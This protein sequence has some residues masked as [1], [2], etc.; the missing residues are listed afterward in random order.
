MGRCKNILQ[1]QK[2][3]ADA[4][5]YCRSN[6]VDLAIIK[7]SDDWYWMIAEPEDIGVPFA[8]S[9]ENWIL[10]APVLIK[11]QVT[12]PEAQ[13]Y[14]R[15]NHLDLYTLQDSSDEVKLYNELAK[16]NEIRPV[17]VGLYNDLDSWYF[18][19]NRLP[20]KNISLRNFASGHPSVE[21]SNAACGAIE[22][23]GLWLALPCHYTGP[24]LC[25][26]ASNSPEHRFVGYINPGLSWHDAQTFCRTHHTD[27]AS[28]TTED[29]INLVKQLL[30]SIFCYGAWFGLTRDTWKWS[31][32]AEASYLPWATGQPDNFYTCE[33]CVGA[34]S[35]LL[36]DEAC[37]NL[38]YFACSD[39]LHRKQFV[40]LQVQTD[41]SVLDPAVQSAVLDLIN[42]KLQ[43]NHMS[44][45][46]TATWKVQADGSIFRKIDS[47]SNSSKA[48]EDCEELNF[49]YN[50]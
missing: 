45:N 34:K 12:W 38:Y 8:L 5:T 7:T 31:D 11:Q 4:K 16:H 33:N 2:H 36:V 48:S 1:K 14:C 6:F 37:N 21:H 18:S 47:P 40:K 23:T 44:V 27:L 25:Y 9:I 24:F 43:E 10:V 50:D 39:Y 26:D 41:E 49:V 20:L 32:G 42:Q 15:Q 28:T 29:D 3:T 17:W 22:D 19:H 35:G 13:I 30:P 46:V